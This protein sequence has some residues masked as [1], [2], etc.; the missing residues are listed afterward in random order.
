LEELDKGGTKSQL[1]GQFK[2]IDCPQKAGPYILKREF[3]FNDFSDFDKDKD[4]KLDFLQNNQAG[5]N[6]K[7]AVKNLQQLGYGTVVSKFILSYNATRDQQQNKRTK[8][9]EIAKQI[10]AELEKK[11]EENHWALDDDQYKKFRDWYIDYRK[12]TW[13][14]MDYLPWL[15]YYN[16]IGCMT[17]SFDV[18]DKQPT[19]ASTGASS[20]QCQ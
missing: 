13:H 12:N 7:D 2:N 14:K 5:T 4:C 8:E 20:F 1:V 10:D 6:Y 19:P 3:C 18:C 17:V 9:A 11:R 16:E 15:L